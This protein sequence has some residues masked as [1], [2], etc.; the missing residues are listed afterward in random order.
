M[1]ILEAMLLSDV[2]PAS[3]AWQ[4]GDGDLVLLAADADDVLVVETVLAT[5]PTRARGQVFIEVDSADQVRQLTAP[6][7]VCVSWLCRDR[8]Q[9]LTAAVDAWLAEMLPVEF[10]REHRVY[11]WRSGDRSA[12]VLTSEQPV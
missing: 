9:S 6:G 5:L 10:D 1:P 4:P 2:L 3:I 11:A 12:R 8:G 7:R